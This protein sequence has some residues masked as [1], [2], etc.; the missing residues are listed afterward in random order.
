MVTASEL[1][2]N[3]ARQEGGRFAMHLG[4]KRRRVRLTAMTRIKRSSDSASA[5]VWGVPTGPWVWVDSGA[6]AHLIPKR[7][8]TAK[9]PRPMHGQGYAHP[10]QRKQLHHPGTGGRGAWRAVKERARREV[11]KIFQEEV[12]KAVS[13]G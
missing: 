1:V 4:K 10:V 11:P 2:E 7:K 12:H 3:I 13:S 8:P 5:T 9:N 6:G